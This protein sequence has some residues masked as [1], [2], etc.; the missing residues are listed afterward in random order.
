MRLG[1]ISL[2][3]LATAAALVGSPAFGQAGPRDLCADRP[4]LGTPTC[5]LD[6]GRVQ[7]ELGIGSWTVDRQPATRTDELI[8]GDLLVR[9]GL[10]SQTELQIGWTPFGRVRVRDRLT[11][12]VDSNSGIG[13]VTLAVRQN[14]LNPDGS[15][16]TL[17]IMP[18]VSIPTGG[19]AI[20]GGDWGAGVRVPFGFDLSDTASIGF[21]PAAEAAVDA[22]GSG[23]HFAYGSV[24]GI[25]VDLAETL[26]A[27]AEVSFTRDQYPSGHSTEALAGLS[28]GWQP[29]GDV[30]LDAGANLGLNRATAD[31][32][33]YFGI[34]RRF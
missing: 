23:R 27:T 14:I 20:G 31:L 29:G 26:N 19:D 30:Q 33:L 5:T 2:A 1:G 13:D 34:S 3:V 8:L 9:I 32:Q 18:Y 21:T 22:D 28:F 4:G 6:P 7:V 16:T 11:G 10:L 12:L 24:A 15:G 25:S 17:A